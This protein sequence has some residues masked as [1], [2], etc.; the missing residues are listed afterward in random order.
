[1]PQLLV[2]PNGTPMQF[3]LVDL[4]DDILTRY[5]SLIEKNGGEVTLEPDETILTFTV[6]MFCFN[7][8]IVYNIQFIDDCLSRKE[9]LNVD[10]YYIGD[11]RFVEECRRPEIIKKI[12]N[13]ECSDCGY[14][15]HVENVQQ[16]KNLNKSFRNERELEKADSDPTNA[17]EMQRRLMD[18]SGSDTEYM[19]SDDSRKSEDFDYDV[20]F[21]PVAEKE[22][23]I[24]SKEKYPK[25][26]KYNELTTKNIVEKNLQEDKNQPSTSGIVDES[27]KNL[28]ELY[29]PSE[30]LKIWAKKIVENKEKD[31]FGFPMPNLKGY[32]HNEKLIL[33]D[34]LVKSNLIFK[35]NDLKVWKLARKLKI[36]PHKKSVK[37]MRAFFKLRILQNIED[38]HLSNEI[39]EKFINYR[40]FGS[41]VEHLLKWAKNETKNLKKD[42]EGF[43]IIEI[44]RRI[45]DLEKEMIVKFLIESKR[46]RQIK[47]DSTWKLAEFLKI[48][49]KERMKQNLGQIVEKEILPNIKNYNLPENIVNQFLKL[50]KIIKNS[51]K[52]D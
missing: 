13:C 47:S 5:I 48:L 50:N 2:R 16:E 15:H 18:D 26:Q 11:D 25:H 37:S 51:P 42:K 29:E 17:N 24:Q 6:P 9:I 46:I 38:F 4:P 34:F 41:L 31:E 49:P 19:F 3:H 22:K 1:M 21:S 36:L 20:V 32:N 35:N 23:I 28:Q 8:S 45:T 12:K 39:Q 52:K 33:I 14:E 44:K 30:Y 43:P 27:E 7:Y 40:T 10:D